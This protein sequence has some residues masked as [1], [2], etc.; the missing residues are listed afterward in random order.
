VADYVP[1]TVSPEQQKQ[2]TLQ[3]LLTI[4]WRIAIPNSL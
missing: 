3:A 4:L 1:L 2:K